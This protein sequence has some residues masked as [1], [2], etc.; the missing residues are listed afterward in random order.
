MDVLVTG[1]T[2]F[3]GG[4][5]AR[6]AVGHGLRVRALRRTD[7]TGALRDLELD[8][9]QGDLLDRASLVRAL[10]GCEVVLHAAGYY[11]TVTFDRA[12]ALRKGVAGMRHLLSAAA[13]AGVR[14]V[15][16]TSTLSTI[17]RAPEGRAADER[18]QY[19][20]GSVD[21]TYW[22]VKWAMEQECW[23]AV[24][25]GQ[26]VVVTNPTICFGPGDVKP[27]SG[28]ILLHLA[29]RRL[30]AFVDGAWNVVD[31]RDVAEAHV[32]AIT[33]G[34]TGHR[35]VLGGH[36]LTVSMFLHHAARIF[37]VPAPRL[38]L[39]GAVLQ[40][41]ALATELA[42][43]VTRRPPLLPLEGVDMIRHGQHF[44]CG[45]AQA[46][47]GLRVRPLAETLADALAWFRA[48]GRLRT[49]DVA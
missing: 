40:S 19:L 26:D 25:E 18:D 30:P 33:R 39:P 42:A 3:L 43:I 49:S 17:G 13:E 12:A 16:Y 4:A 29:R 9:R 1:A 21:D 10:R 8:W 20:P 6:A 37:G 41:A 11:P 28:A 15:I 32:A 38:Q 22:E 2:G 48:E 47:L 44:D 46:E 35:Y 45:K 31:V 27:T 24:A 5:V 36:N 14:R 34:R 23:R 7:A